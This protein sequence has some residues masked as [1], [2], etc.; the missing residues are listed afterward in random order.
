MNYFWLDA[1]ALAKRYLPETGTL[2]VNYLFA[3]VPLQRLICLF[4]G[5]GEV[6][7]IFV[8]H[9]NAG[10]I[11]VSGFNQIIQDFQSE[12]PRCVELE[13]IHPT[14]SQV[15]AS[16]EFIETH[17]INST[18]AIILHCALDKAIE[19]RTDEADLIMVSADLRLLRAAEIE[20][21]LTVNPETD[22]QTKIEQLV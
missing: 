5:I 11:T 13:K 6:I 19:L 8:R 16:W 20:G 15:V 21:I 9:R 14:E 10:A 1:S 2:L 22:S 12:V 7:S 4:E 18:D 17:S 3:H